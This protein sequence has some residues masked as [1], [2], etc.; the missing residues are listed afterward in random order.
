M[1]IIQNE[2]KAQRQMVD[3]K[4]NAVNEGIRGLDT[5]HESVNG[6]TTRCNELSTQFN[7]FCVK[8]NRY[9]AEHSSQQ[10]QMS[11]FRARMDKFNENMAIMNKQAKDQ[12][13]KQ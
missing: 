7:A 13:W 10:E 5:L 12:I 9:E 4:L 11:L 8:L 2:A 6:V 3:E 1:V